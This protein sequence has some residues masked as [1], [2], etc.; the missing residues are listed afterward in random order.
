MSGTVL[1][2]GKER[3][4]G[5]RMGNTVQMARRRDLTEFRN[6]VMAQL[7]PAAQ[8]FFAKRALTREI[9][10]GE[11]LYEEGAPFT[12]AVFPHEGVISLMAKMESGRTI[13]KTSIGNEGFL[14]FSLLMGGSGA[15]SR[16][17]V[18]VP[19]YA[20][21]ISV[22]QL[23]EALSDFVCVRDAMLRYAK[24]LIFQTMESVACNGLHTAEQRVSRWLLHALDRVRGD[25]FAVTQQALAEVLGLRRQTVSEVCSHLQADG[26]IDYSRGT[27][28]VVRRD[29]LQ[30]RSCECYER[31]RRAS[32][33]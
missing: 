2:Y 13:E 9:A 8:E 30:Q 19:G 29:A 28:T 31:V 16:T 11:V 6:R 23:D 5:D 18:Q 14:G 12:H 21:W 25:S 24:S 32:L 27:L 17:V 15:I 10:A 20:S 22:E 1:T 3:V 7:R 26:V 33:L 4:N